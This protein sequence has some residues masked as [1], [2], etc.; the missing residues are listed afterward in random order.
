MSEQMQFRIFTTRVN[1]QTKDIG[2][3]EH[4]IT[5]I[6]ECECGCTQEELFPIQLVVADEIYCGTDRVEI[7][8]HIN[9]RLG[10]GVLPAGPLDLFGSMSERCSC[11]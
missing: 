7:R 1:A 11:P 9:A 6:I 3:H 10:A 2:F 8:Q 5:Q 4:V